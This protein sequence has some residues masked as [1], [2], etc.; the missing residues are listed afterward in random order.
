MFCLFV[1]LKHTFI[2]TTLPVV[3]FIHVFISLFIHIACLQKF[4]GSVVLAPTLDTISPFETVLFIFSRTVQLQRTTLVIY[5]LLA[6]VFS[7]FS[8]F[9]YNLFSV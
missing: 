6:F 4:L 3:L 1:F 7:F 8:V 2:L 9:V 5:F